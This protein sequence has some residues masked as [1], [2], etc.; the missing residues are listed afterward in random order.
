MSH[1]KL[2]RVGMTNLPMNTG[3]YELRTK[4]MSL[5]YEALHITGGRRLLPRVE[6]RI[7][8]KKGRTLGVASLAGVQHIS[9]VQSVIESGNEALLRHVVF[10]ELCHTWFKIRHSKSCPLMNN[11]VSQPVTKE[12]AC[13]IIKKYYD[14]YRTN[15]S[16][17]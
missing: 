11:T 8:L 15:Q 9:I 3:T 17:F 14:E 1:T 2:N 7:V 6:V 13:I 16:A 5:I 10:H 12:L 4:V